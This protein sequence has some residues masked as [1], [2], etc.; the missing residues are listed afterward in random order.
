MNISDTTTV[1]DLAAGVPGA[2]RVFENFGID[3]CCGGHRTLADACREAGLPVE[4]LTR[5]LEKA[6]GAPQPCSGRDWQQ[7][8]L[9]A[10]TEYIIDTHHFFT[11]Q[12]LDRL[13]NLFDRVCSRHGENHPELFGAQKTFYQLKQD[14]IPHMLKE[15]QVLFPYITRMEEAAR[16]GRAIPPP[17]FGTVRNPVRMMMTEHDTAGDLLRQLR[18]ITKGYTTPSDGCV[19]YQTLCQTLA[20]FEA[21]L[22]QHIHLENNVLF[23]R[24]VETE[25]TS[26][27][28]FYKSA[29]E[30]NEHRCFGR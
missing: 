8:S 30:F 29:G 25:E 2:T 11:R 1:R 16:E 24:A 22:H 21:D 19:S 14:M 3:Y 10:L 15:E 26:A 4:D 20:A 28:G 6:G 18:G 5:S 12:E 9:T 17:F 27:P 7:E 13:E 23:P